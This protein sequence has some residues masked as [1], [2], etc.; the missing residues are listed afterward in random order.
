MIKR[1]K[2]FCLFILFSCS[3]TAQNPSYIQFE[4]NDGL[5]SNEVYDAAIGPDG[6]VWFTTDRGV[7]SYDGYTFTGYTTSDGLADNT[8][9]EINKDSE[10]RLWFCGFTG[11]LS[12]YDHGTFYPY[13][14]NDLLASLLGDYWIG[15]IIEA[16]EGNYYFTPYKATGLAIY[17]LGLNTSPS[18]INSIDDEV[19]LNILKINKDTVIRINQS[20]Y[21][22]LNPNTSNTANPQVAVKM[23]DHW[24]AYSGQFLYKSDLNGNTQ[25]IEFDATVTN[26]HIDDEQNLWVCSTNG[27]F[28]FP[29]GN[30]D[31][32]PRQYFGGYHIT[33][34]INDP[35]NNYWLTTYQNGVLM[36]PSF[37]VGTIHSPGNTEE[38]MLSIE[39]LK[40]HIYFGTSDRMVLGIDSLKEISIQIKNKAPHVSQI[41][42]INLNGSELFASG[43]AIKETNGL[44]SYEDKWKLKSYKQLLSNG[45]FLVFEGNSFVILNPEGKRIIR[46][47]DLLLL[48]AKKLNAAVEDKQQNIWLG[49]LKGLYKISQFDYSTVEPILYNQKDTFGRINDIVIDQHDHQWIATIG[50]GLFYRTEQ[51]LFHIKKEDGLC[52]DLINQMYLVK[53]SIICLATNQGLSVFNYQYVNGQL[54][55]SQIKTLNKNDGLSSNFINDVNFWKDNV[56][57]ATDKGINY[58]DLKILNRPAPIVPIVINDMI[59]N[60]SSYSLTDELVFSH[61]QNDVFID[62]TGISFR[63]TTDDNFYRYR[64]NIDEQNASWFYSNEKNIRYNDLAPGKYTFEVSAQNNT[65]QWNSDP[66]QLS[67]EIK[68]H[69]T[70]TAWFKIITALLVLGL[71]GFIVYKQIQR[72]K[73]QEQRKRQ[74]QSA[75]LRTREAELAALRNQMNPHF[76]FNSL[77]S[78]QNFIFKKDTEKANYFLSKFSGLMRKSLQYTRLDFITIQEEMSFLKD[79]LELEMMRFPDKFQYT[80]NIDEQLE[81]DHIMLPS[82]LLQPILENS[83][84]HGFKETKTDGLIEIEVLEKSENSLEIYIRDNG[85]GLKNKSIQQKDNPDHKSLGMQ[86][87]RNRIDLLNEANHNV[88]SSVNFNN[89]SDI[90]S[91]THGLEVHFILPILYKT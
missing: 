4:T 31:N 49:S 86:I 15:N 55:Y 20:G 23:G 19:D 68:P 91:S 72:T 35:E 34:I 11:W 6:L 89:R 65:Q 22:F 77:N 75:E 83:V 52:S 63:K 71:I 27:L 33:S 3:L 54:S 56:W 79:Y 12:I 26:T 41:R 66:A 78:I 16:S 67:F 51:Q 90:D 76:V 82:L 40:D 37:E 60:D 48:F 84:K 64:L 62:F 1:F 30:L 18:R 44:I 88:V 43:I 24:I 10:G 21:S 80:I 39:K 70:Q 36:V 45:Q 58:F 29:E 9:F 50:N 47:K 57:L 85:G 87:I 53:D 5:S 17:K 14:H 69:F 73:S 32:S 61:E 28:L 25:Q 74:L 59:V 81:D 7:C 42:F 2:S 13:A 46:A 38:R 8:N